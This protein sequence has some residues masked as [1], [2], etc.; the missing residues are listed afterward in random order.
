MT[1]PQ[2]H[3][4]KPCWIFE[5]WGKPPASLSKKE[6][7]LTTAPHRPDFLL[8]IWFGFFL[9]F[10]QSWQLRLSPSKKGPRLNHGIYASRRPNQIWVWIF[11]LFARFSASPSKKGP[12]LNHSSCESRLPTKI[13][14]WICRC[15]EKLSLSPLKRARGLITL[16]LAL[17][18][19]QM[20]RITTGS[21][22]YAFLY[23]IAFPKATLPL[24]A[25]NSQGR[26]LL[27]Q[28]HQ[29]MLEDPGTGKHC[30]LPR[31]CFSRL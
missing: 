25:A 31:H 30:L 4:W 12:R 29:Q 14:L 22:A 16:Y 10:S 20:P 15:L 26:K 11:R 19:D 28:L 18:I 6:R 13:W 27:K 2:V 1:F 7:G 9:Q 5:I 17:S 24:M 21:T 23:L 3:P 8:R